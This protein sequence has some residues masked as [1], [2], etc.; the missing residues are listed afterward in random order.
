MP[1]KA[2]AR[3]WALYFL[4]GSSLAYAEGAGKRGSAAAAEQTMEQGVSALAAKD[5]ALALSTLTQAYR[6]YQNPRVLFH[7]GALAVAEQ[8]TVDAQDLLQRFLADATVDPADPLQEQARKLLATLQVKE[9]G[10]LQLIAPRGALIEV[11][12]RVVGAL[13][14]PRPLL[15]ATGTHLVAIS[16]GKWRA[17]Q[18]VKVQ[19]ARTCEV[20]FKAGSPVVVVTVP[21]AVLVLTQG[22][23]APLQDKL[24]Q[25]LPLLLKRENLVPVLAASAQRYFG[26]LAKC[27][28]TATCLKP[29]KEF[30][31]DSVLLSKL[32]RAGGGDDKAAA[33]YQL[34]LELLDVAVGAVAARSQTQCDRC[35]PESLTTHFG[36][37][38]SK[39]LSESVER[40][41]SE[42]SITSTPAGAEVVVNQ[43]SLGKTPLTRMVFSGAVA[44]QVRLDGYVT[45]ERTLE[46]KAGDSQQVDVTLKTEQEPEPSALLS[47]EGLGQP[48]RPAWRLAVGGAAI[49]VG[50]GILGLGIAALY[51]DNRC[52]GSGE[53][54]M[55]DVF[56]NCKTD[57]PNQAKF[58][59]T[60]SLGIGLTV[61]GSALAIG[62]AVLVALPPRR[63]SIQA[64]VAP[65]ASG[66]HLG[67]RA[68]F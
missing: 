11:D 32:T 31:A 22:V 6:T 1:S 25:S 38:V 52:V 60:Q 61:V 59:Q 62:G 54:S 42:L 47:T 2:W 37:A 66:L 19:T 45:D 5:Y 3:L 50:V 18:E 35:T 57:V 68:R 17:Q 7:L 28:S 55:G 26:A 40:G 58:Y 67:L 43:Q 56:A 27:S 24:E 15:Q 49:G 41:R 12:G 63:A 21:P 23:E 39:L 65:A 34:E 64:F 51:L 30:G 16:Q 46:T 36:S 13:P 14:L 48:K 20:R 4:T 29:A 33:T 44:L 53:P 8:R 10:E 9:A